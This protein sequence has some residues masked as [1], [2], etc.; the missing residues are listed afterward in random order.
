MSVKEFCDMCKV[1]HIRG[2]CPVEREHPLLFSGGNPMP[3][4]TDKN[5]YLAERMQKHWHEWESHGYKYHETCETC[6]MSRL[7]K[8]HGDFEVKNPD[9]FDADRQVLLEWGVEQE[10]WPL[11]L[12]QYFKVLE[13]WIADPNWEGDHEECDIRALRRWNIPIDLL[14][15]VSALAEAVYEYLKGEEDADIS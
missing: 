14:I 10:W 15:P 4:Q 7:D 2:M 5:R 3:N 8:G 9:Y 1:Y 13:E 11:F 6:F 12:Y